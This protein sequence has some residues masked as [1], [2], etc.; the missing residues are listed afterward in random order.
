M[1]TE[2]KSDSLHNDRI[3]ILDFGF[4]GHAADRP[5]R[6]RER[7][8]LRD[9]ALLGHPRAH[10]R[11]QC[12][13]HHIVRR[14]RLGAGQRLARA[15]Q[16]A[17][18]S[19][20]AGAGHLLWPA[21]PCARSWAASSP[22]ADTREFGRAFVDI[23][24]PCALDRRR[25]GPRRPAAGVDEPRRPR[26]QSC[27]PAFRTVGVSEGAPFAMI[28][29]DARKYYGL[30]FHPEVVHTRPHGRAADPQLHPRCL[31]L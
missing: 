24:E 14:P 20:P 23:R 9:P 18:R 27:P 25:L 3:L 12:P 11:L 16:G 22:W 7:G 28:A 26:H 6:A 4:A 19:R 30:M 8:L 5:P 2:I 15:G 31:R 10:P 13:R 29:D 1:S 17:V 21:D